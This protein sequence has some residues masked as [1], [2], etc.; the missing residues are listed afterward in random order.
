MLRLP[1]MGR[2]FDELPV[3]DCGAAARLSRRAL[4]RPQG[5]CFAAAVLCALI[6]LLAGVGPTVEWGLHCLGNAGRM[7]CAGEVLGQCRGVLAW[8]LAGAV[9]S[10]VLVYVT[11]AHLIGYHLLFTVRTGI[12]LRV[13]GTEEQERARAASR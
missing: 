13:L 6:G 10:F 8:R 11:F 3:A 4:L 5:L 7:R 2:S 12:H 9:A 1:R